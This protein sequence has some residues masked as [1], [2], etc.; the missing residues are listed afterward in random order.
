[1]TLLTLKQGLLGRTY[2]VP[3][4]LAVLSGGGLA[5]ALIGDAAFDLA[6]W[7]MLGLPVVIAGWFSF[8]PARG[9]VPR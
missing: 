6:S 3:T 2:A 9:S 5:L 4:A 7:L 8:A 1:M